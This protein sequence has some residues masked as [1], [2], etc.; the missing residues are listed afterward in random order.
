MAKND[1]ELSLY[2]E[3]LLLSSAGIADMETYTW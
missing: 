2:K 1:N 3:R